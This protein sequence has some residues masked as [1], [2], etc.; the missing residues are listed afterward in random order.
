MKKIFR[1]WIR[2]SKKDVKTYQKS[3]EDEDFLQKAR[4][5]YRFPCGVTVVAV[6]A[7]ADLPLEEPAVVAA[8][9]CCL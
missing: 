9:V 8:G 6:A 2:L 7:P 5:C 4:C 1:L 3:E